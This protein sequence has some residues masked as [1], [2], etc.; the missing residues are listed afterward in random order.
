M[1][2]NLGIG[3]NGRLGNQLFQFAALYGTAKI[4]GYEFV[5][6]RSNTN[7]NYSKTMDGKPVVFRLE[8]VD[9]FEIDHLLGEPKYISLVAR[10]RH[11]HFDN[12]ILIIPDNTTLDGYFQS[13][14]YF[15][16]CKDDLLDTL[17]FKS[18]IVDR[19]KTLLPRKVNQ[20]VSIHVRRGDYTFPNPYHPVL[21]TE[22]FNPA[23][24][25]FPGE[26]FHFVV[27]SDDPQWCRDTWGEDERFT[28]VD[29]GDTFADLCAM[30]MCDHNIISNSSFSWWASYLNK[31]EQKTIIAPARWFG[32]GYKDHILSD[33]YTKEMKVI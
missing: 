13:E 32:T 4:N 12:S 8:L 2:T 10:E 11:F 6:P 33:L 30:S 29:S 14:R 17:R 7:A 5:I 31:N 21:G 9:C 26:D 20:L 28:I 23:I 16:H 1:I 22:Y 15:V 24:S 19:A 25:L 18:E 3:Y 27:F